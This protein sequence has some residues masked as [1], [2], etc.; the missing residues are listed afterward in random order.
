MNR[1]TLTVVQ[2][3]APKPAPHDPWP[4]PTG[5]HPDQRLRTTIQAARQAGYEAGERE[6]YTTGWRHG[7][8][9]ALLAGMAIGAVGMYA[10]TQ[11]APLLGMVL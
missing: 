8:G 11:L 7:V 9:Q 10:A 5:T 6:G 4:V 1:P 3:P 2:T